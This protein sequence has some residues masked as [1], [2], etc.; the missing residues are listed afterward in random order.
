M[1]DDINEAQDSEVK[2]KDCVAA[3]SCF[4]NNHK[5]QTILLFGN[6]QKY[7][8]VVTSKTQT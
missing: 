2:F 4:S 6:L 7:E 3:F 1:P 8:A 5:L